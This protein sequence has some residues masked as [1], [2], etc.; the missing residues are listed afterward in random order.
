MSEPI[1]VAEN[2]PDKLLSLRFEYA[3]R[4]FNFHASQRTTMF[5][6]F[7]VFSGFFIGA[8]VKSL[9]ANGTPGILTL[10][11]PIVGILIT[12]M[13]IFLDRRNEELVHIAEDVLKKL[14]EDLFRDYEFK[15]EVK[16]RYLW[17]TM[18]SYPENNASI[19]VTILNRKIIDTSKN[20]HGTWLPCIELLLIIVYF[21]L[22]LLTIYHMRG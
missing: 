3:W 9:P 17:G 21:F 2:K 7:L 8:Y 15:P 10:M 22:L 1:P 4:Y 18:K 19:K 11:L 16:R 6:F 13:F 14:E 12:T 20:R 5:N